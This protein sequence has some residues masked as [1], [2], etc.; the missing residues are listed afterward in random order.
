MVNGGST[1]NSFYTNPNCSPVDIRIFKSCYFGFTMAAALLFCLLL[2]PQT[3]GEQPEAP[4]VIP[5]VH[6]SIV[7]TASPVEV[8]MDHRNSEVFSQTL[9]S[10]DD[11]IFHVLDAGINA[12]QHEGGGKSVE[13]RR[14]GFN[15]DHGGVNGGLKVLVNNVQQNQST[16]G[17]GQ[18]YLGSLKTVTPELVQEVNVIN[19]PF[20]A[21]Y[22]DFSG[23]GVVHIVLRESF[24]DQWTARIQGGSF[25]AMRGF[26]SWSPDIKT[27]DALIAYEGAYTDGP[28]KNPLLYRRD[29]L[30]GTYTKRLS[31]QQR[32]GFK[33][34]GGRNHFDSSGQIPLDQVQAGRLDT[35]GAIDPSNG[36]R[37]VMGTASA[38][39]RRDGA[40]GQTLRIDGFA[41]RSL[42]DLYSNFTFWLNDPVH[43]DAFQQHDS[44]LQEGANAQYVRPHKLW[45]LQSLLTTGGNFHDNQINV[46]LYPRVARVPVDTLTKADAHVT[47]GAGYVQESVSA[48]H[49]RMQVT[50]G[51]RFDEFRFRVRELVH[52]ENG[53]I[54]FGGRW[55]PKAG[56]AY[57]PSSRAAVTLHANY[58]RG[59]ST[60]DARV[61]VQHP[62]LPRIATTDFMQLGLT[63]HA[64][65]VSTAASVFLI[66]RSNEQVYVPDDGTYEFKGP[67]RSYGFETKMSV[68]LTRHLS[69]NGSITKVANSFYRGSVPRLYVDSAPHFVA[70][71]G[72]TLS[73]WKGW[74]GSLRMRAI[75]HYRLDQQDPS[76]TATG[77]TVFDFGVSRKIR[78]GVE[79]NLTLDNLTNRTYFE[80]QNYFESRLQYQPAIARIHA[81]PGYPLTAMAGL[82]FRLAGK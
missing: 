69:F 27:G 10:R 54:E 77:H 39:Y 6:T 30:N 43:G 31:R 26:L 63:H 1:P 76:I 44:R 29:N 33:F 25:G 81:T 62:E 74:S 18:G 8:D 45:G 23:L 68:D 38:Y 51:L 21:E 47:N 11:Q 3:P 28:F 2:A 14:F 57:T 60:A 71:A 32:I 17:H 37:S 79:C 35:F 41:G 48:L 70:G 80:T 61:V 52:P 16:Q 73:S 67:S 46:G 65:R 7:I 66:D 42:L 72:L 78:K 4:T 75:N 36:G 58:G 22:G 64:G 13:V 50:G 82:T 49:G 19:G 56:F 53:G 34:I 12:G 59:I 20:S 9:F 15:L 40:A 55:Q 24:P 5:P